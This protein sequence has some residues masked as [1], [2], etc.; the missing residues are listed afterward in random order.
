VPNVFASLFNIVYNKAEIIDHWGDNAKDVFDQIIMVVNG[1]FFP[2]G[3]LGVATFL[4]PILGGLKRVRRGETLPAAELAQLRMRCLRLGSVSA[5]VC[6]ACWLAA[7]LVWPVTLRLAVGPP[8]DVAS[9]IHFTLSLVICGLVAAA[10]PYFI[11]TFVAVRVLYPA[12]LGPGGP[13]ASDRPALKRV[14]REL[15]LFRAAAT[16]VPLVAVA[17]L[18]SLLAVRSTTVELAVAVLSAAGLLG[19]LLAFALE[20]RTRAD[21]AALADI[22][23]TEP[24]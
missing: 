1:I 15:S 11:I 5:L 4:W 22:P 21:L 14:E 16:A 9:Y 17:L 23:T 19:T 10:Y 20:G 3:M 8:P 6:V 24:R 12:L 7:G 18:A 2:L 13:A